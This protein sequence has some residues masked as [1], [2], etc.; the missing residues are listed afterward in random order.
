MIIID[1]KRAPQAQSLLR[2][3][4]SIKHQIHKYG[5]KNAP[6]HLLRRLR[7]L[8]RRLRSAKH[9][10]KLRVNNV[11]F[12]GAGLTCAFD[13]D[14]CSGDGTNFV[15]ELYADGR[16]YGGGIDTEPEFVAISDDSKT[17]YVTLQENNAVAVIS[18]Q[19]SGVCL[20]GCPT[21]LQCSACSE[22]SESREPV[23]PLHAGA[24]AHRSRYLSQS[25]HAGKIEQVVGL[26]RK[27]YSTVP[28][29][30]GDNGKIEIEKYDGFVG[31]YQPDSI[32]YQ[33][34]GGKGYL[35][36]ANEGDARDGENTEASECA[37]SHIEPLQWHGSNL[38]N[39]RVRTRL[40]PLRLN[41]TEI[42]CKS[43]SSLQP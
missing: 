5:S 40:L 36:T 28:L 13:C 25:A 39:M 11:S 16:K 10:V 41:Q 23:K 30:L 26:G 21:C 14:V 37:T 20:S 3:I 4:R 29:D 8:E 42:V 24:L 12:I 38:H 19:G 43:P 34:I 2:L 1:V 6:Q 22:P 15:P 32:A 31:L 33:S 35:F 17:A 18:L 27:D 7:N 9:A